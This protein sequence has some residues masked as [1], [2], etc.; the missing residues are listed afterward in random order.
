VGT[1]FT[2]PGLTD[3]LMHVFEARGLTPVPRRLEVG[4]EIEVAERSVGEVEHLI[5]DGGIRDAKTIGAFAQW[6]LAGG[7]VA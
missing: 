5:R 6:R 1:F 7:G 4:E 2:S 3:E